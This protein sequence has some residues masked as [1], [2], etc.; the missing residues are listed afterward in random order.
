MESR[1]TS[2]FSETA[3]SVTFSRSLYG[4]RLLFFSSTPI[5]FSRLKV[6]AVEEYEIPITFDVAFR[7]SLED[8]LERFLPGAR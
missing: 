6:E 3:I 7:F 4:E 1:L 8:T 2:C 5:L